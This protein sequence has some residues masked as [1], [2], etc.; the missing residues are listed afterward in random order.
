MIPGRQRRGSSGGEAAVKAWTLRIARAIHF[1]GPRRGG[2][3]I[4]VNWAAITEAF[5]QTELFGFARGAFKIS[6]PS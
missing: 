4:E 6:P 1:N 5:F 3:L 2:P